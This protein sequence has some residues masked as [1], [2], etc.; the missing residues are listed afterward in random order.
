MDTM[1]FWEALMKF[2]ISYSFGKDSALAFYRMLQ[3]GHQPVA[4]LTAYNAELGRNWFHG[5]QP[6]LMDAVKKSL[7]LPL[8]LCDC[9][10]SGYNKGFEAGLVEAR[11]I[12]AEACVF[13]D[14]DIEDHAE[15]NRARSRAVGLDC[16]LP[17]WHENRA[18][19]VQ[20]NID[21]GIKAMITSVQTD[22]LDESFLGQTLT[23]PLA[24]KIAKTG[25]D[26]CG[27]NGEYHTF[28][29]DGP[30]FEHPVAIQNFGIVNLGTHKVADI[31]LR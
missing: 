18:M 29:Y 12:G 15:Y 23:L 21:V 25:A 1:T 3:S 4:L 9:T 24:Q 28:V 26:I 27:E 31:R 14:I 16:M 13:G 5:I 11:K 17:L 19:L 10:S 8:I 2:V 30:M 7:G 22:A 20:E 6:D